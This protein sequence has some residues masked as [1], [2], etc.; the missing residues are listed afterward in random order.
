ML[1]L[2]LVAAAPER[3]GKHMPKLEKFRQY[4]YEATAK[5][6]DNTRT[7]AISAI[8]IVWLFKTEKN[9]LY[10]VSESLL[11]PLALVVLA[12][13]LDFFQYIYRSVVWHV[14][15]RKKEKELANGAITEESELYVSPWVNTMAYV[16]FYAKALILT[17]AYWN[18]ACYLYST[19][20][21]A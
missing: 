5:V 2:Q 7:L 14:I 4:H 20:K 16:F 11:W 9:G 8:A 13:A 1:V 3:S 18:L 10:V 19:V 17:F 12:L 15:F 21:W 6:S